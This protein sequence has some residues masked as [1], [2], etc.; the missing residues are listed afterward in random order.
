MAIGSVNLTSSMRNNLVTL[1]NTAS[2]M[3]TAENHLATGNKVNSAVDNPASFFAAQGETSRGT[4]LSGLKDNI[5]QAIQ[6][7]NAASNGITGEQALIES[8]RGVI[9]QA[10]S[11]INDKVNSATILSGAASGSDQGLTKQY[12]SLV[13]QLNNLVHDA[14][15]QGVNFLTSGSTSTATLTVNFN[16]NAST[17]IT[18]SGFNA[19]ASGLG[20][21]GGGATK[22]VTANST[23]N[24]TSGSI[25]NATNLNKMEASL[26]TALATLQTQSSALAANL[27]ILT[28]RQS[29]ITSMVNTLSVGATSLVGTD[30]NTESANLLT[31][32]TQNQLGVTSLSMSNQANSAV[33]KLF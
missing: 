25:N 4:Q 24:L 5:G 18:M 26:N 32:Q 27:S 29:F 1:Q 22:E 19:G 10:R 2:L 9:T 28:A 6:T 11:A 15:F 20:I 12:N 16:E 21:S 17:S 33:L 13:G 31:L 7:V 8:L 14:S 3:S 30:T 23:G